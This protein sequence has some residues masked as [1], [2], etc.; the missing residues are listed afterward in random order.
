MMEYVVST[1]SL[2]SVGQQLSTVAAPPDDAK[3]DLWVR[4]SRE[5]EQWKVRIR[6]K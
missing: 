3:S 4:I 6:P 5:L 1:R 2:T